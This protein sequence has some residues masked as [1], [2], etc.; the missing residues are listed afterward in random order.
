M[1]TG[2]PLAA[3]SDTTGLTASTVS[4]GNVSTLFAGLFTGADVGTRA[5]A[6]YVNSIGGIHGRRLV[7][8]TYD[9]GFSGAPNKQ[10]TEEATQRDFAL[11]GGFSLQDNFGGTVLAVSPQV[12]NVTVSLDHGTGALPNSFSPFPSQGGWGLGP[13]VYFQ[14]RF[15]AGVKAIGVLIADQPS[16]V[17]TWGREQAAME[18]V[19]YH[20]AYDAQF[21]ITQTDFNQNVIA[22]RNAG[23]KML[24]VDQ[25]P[26]NYA[27][28]V[29]RA[30]RQQNFH[31][32]V[33]F[34]PSSYS[35]ALVPDAGGAPA[36]DGA[37]LYQSMSLYLGED[38]A[39]IPSVVTFRTWV[40]KVAPGFRADLFTLYGWTSAELFAQAL[41]SAGPE[42]SRGSVLRALR[43]ITEFDGGHLIA[44]SNPSAKVG[45]N[46]Y[47]IGRIEAGRFQRIDDPPVASST[48]GYRCDQP[49]WNP[50]A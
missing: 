1:P 27:A 50:S 33:V 25:M 43:G 48:H 47:L 41:A 17:T 16:A 7:V 24:F 28:A 34:G 32:V 13:L 39:A 2:I 31:P 26:E 29:V 14:K 42:P 45:S 18:H 49:P 8:D 4:I 12:P 46:C 44:T 6:A 23:V 19:G 38:A 35:E 10:H 40:D 30:L 22:M 3:F 11:V 36:I 21:A 37:Y 5:Y 9:D 15:P 20:V